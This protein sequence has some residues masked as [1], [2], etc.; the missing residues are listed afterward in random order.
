MHRT[1][2]SSDCGEGDTNRRSL[3]GSVAVSDGGAGVGVVC[4][5]ICAG[6]CMS[7]GGIDWKTMNWLM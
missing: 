4:I 1:G 5:L 3:S 6:G 7:D 2:W